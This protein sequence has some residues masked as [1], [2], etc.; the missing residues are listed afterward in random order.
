M[1]GMEINMQKITFTKKLVVSAMLIALAVVTSL[2]AFAS[3]PFGGSIT[4]FS[5]LFVSLIGYFYGVKL[6]IMAGV[7]YG[8]IQFAIKPFFYLPIQVLLDYPLAFGV[9]GLSGVFYKKKHGLL[10]G[11]TVGVC[12][13]YVFHVLSGYLFFKS[14]VPEN[15]NAIIY[16]LGYNST[17]I[18]PELIATLVL[19]MIPNISN[20]LE[21]IKR[22]A[23]N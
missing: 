14:N 3:L 2:I 4:M 18:L 8:L 13:R 11:Y 10:I 9:L 16:T 12:G 5:M 7:A 19:L 6:G 21:K 17:Y 22:M 1:K 23:N 20:S 15:T